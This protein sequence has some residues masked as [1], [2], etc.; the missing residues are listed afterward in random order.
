MPSLE[1]LIAQNKRAVLP[2]LRVPNSKQG[3]P[4]FPAWHRFRK[5][6]EWIKSLKFMR[7]DSDPVLRR[8]IEL[9]HEALGYR[10]SHKRENKFQ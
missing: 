5:S 10:G 9:N 4:C 2:D 7:L 6:E 1:S 3:P 8:P